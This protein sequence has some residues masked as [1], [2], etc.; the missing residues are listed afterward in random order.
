MLKSESD[1]A[2]QRLT[3]SYKYFEPHKHLGKGKYRFWRAVFYAFRG[4]E[5][6]NVASCLI[7][8]LVG[9]V[10]LKGMTSIHTPTDYVMVYVAMITGAVG[11]TATCAIELMW[12]QKGA[13]N[14]EQKYNISYRNCI[15]G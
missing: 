4:V 8:V 2:L 12:W 13:I 14:D 9:V 10:C 11:F 1:F 5:I 15:S 7:M 3:G 6:K